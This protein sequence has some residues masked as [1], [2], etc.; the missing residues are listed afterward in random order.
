[1]SLFPD[2]DD[3]DYIR[4]PDLAPAFIGSAYRC[5]LD[6]PVAVYD[7]ELL[8]QLFMERDEMSEEDAVEY[9]DYNI[10]GAYIGERTPLVLHMHPEPIEEDDAEESS[11]A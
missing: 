4:H 11:D 2:L 7:Y 6:G 5:G 3:E 8:V 9:I 1:M 10:L